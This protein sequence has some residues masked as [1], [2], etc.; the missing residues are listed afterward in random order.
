MHL[1]LI[2]RISKTK[3]ADLKVASI[4]CQSSKHCCF[5]DIMNN[6]DIFLSQTVVS[7]FLRENVIYTWK[8]RH[9]TVFKC[10]SLISIKMLS[11]V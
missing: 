4:Q 7:V 3:Y 10:S 2:K 11:T 6:Y 1:L 5:P 8:G 9:S